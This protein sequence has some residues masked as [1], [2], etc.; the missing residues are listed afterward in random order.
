MAETPPIKPIQTGLSRIVIGLGLIWDWLEKP[1]I[2]MGS[3]I[4]ADEW[5]IISQGHI[6]RIGPELTPS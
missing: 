3:E 1:C 6:I 5:G 4:G 2:S